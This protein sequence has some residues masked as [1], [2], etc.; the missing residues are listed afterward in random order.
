MSYK[1]YQQLTINGN[2]FEGYEICNFCKAQKQAHYDHIAE[3]AGQWLNDRPTVTVTTS[4]STGEP[5]TFEVKKSAMLKSAQM[6]ADYFGFKKGDKALL[7]LSTQYI[8]GKMMMV[9]AFL[10]G[11]NLI[12][13]PPSS[14]PLANLEMEID[15]APLVPM[16][17][18]D[19]KNLQRVKKIL[20]GG[21]P[22]SKALE[23]SLQHTPGLIFHGYGMTE[24]LSH[25]A[26]RHVNGPERSAIYTALPGISFS[27]N[28]RACLQIEAPFLEKKITTSDVVVLLNETNFLWKGRYDSVINSGGIKLFPEELE[29]KISELIPY[30]YFISGK[31]DERL[32]QKVVLVIEAKISEDELRD[33]ETLVANKLSPFERPKN[34][35]LTEKFCYTESG[36]IDRNETLRIIS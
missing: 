31:A 18:H 11:L 8:A 4:G 5:K 29:Q 22:L 12:C 33:L 9:R 19:Q 20:L 7:C 16:Q 35:L 13:I 34:I 6:T 24:T 27:T 32:G 17:V 21:A 30:N 26:I 25:V 10:S 36:K 23:K 14:S 15:F 1:D 2:T 28:D 3:F